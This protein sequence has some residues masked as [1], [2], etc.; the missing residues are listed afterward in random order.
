MQKN[1]LDRR[2][3]LR[4]PPNEH[5]KRTCYPN[6]LTELHETVTR[7]TRPADPGQVSG[8]DFILTVFSAAISEI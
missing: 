4:R 5:L 3:D 2:F 6:Y 8:K 1:N 7:T